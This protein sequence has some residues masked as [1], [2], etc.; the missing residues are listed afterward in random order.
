MDEEL[1]QVGLCSLEQRG[2]R[3]DSAEVFKIMNELL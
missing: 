1:L 2:A 3:E